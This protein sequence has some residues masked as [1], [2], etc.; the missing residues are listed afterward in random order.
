MK[1]P[2]GIMQSGAQE[3]RGNVVEN[4]AESE[5]N[6]IRWNRCHEVVTQWLR[7]GV[8]CR[9]PFERRPIRFRIVGA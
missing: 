4:I 6:R 7:G 5:R 8:I 2:L 1:S 9:F 3:V